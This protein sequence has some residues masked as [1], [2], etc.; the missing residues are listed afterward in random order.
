MARLTGSEEQVVSLFPMFNILI[1]TL[2]V[3]I[4]ILSTL[5]TI[6][7]GVGKSVVIIPETENGETH[8]KIPVYME[9]NGYDLTLHPSKETIR[10]AIDIRKIEAYEKTYE[11]INLKIKST[12]FETLF[13]DLSRN[14]E[15][16]YIILLIRPSG[17]DNLRDI[18]GYIENKGIDIGYEPINQLL[19][20]RIR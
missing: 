14:K 18:R 6:S 7:I 3:F 15:K 1:C 19:N 20:L 10:F 2:G 16:K 5:A 13:N 4:F 11:Y 8:N 9:W 17:F 12:E